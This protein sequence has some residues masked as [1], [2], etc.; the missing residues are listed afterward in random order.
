MSAH[1]H[2]LRA[3]GFELDSALIVF[4]SCD[5]TD[6]RSAHLFL[7]TLEREHSDGMQRPFHRA[8]ITGFNGS[9]CSRWDVIDLL[10]Q[11]AIRRNAEG[12]R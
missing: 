11:N 2:R 6:P 3:V 1:F 8:R 10:L 12:P 5:R 4:S 9:L 7:A